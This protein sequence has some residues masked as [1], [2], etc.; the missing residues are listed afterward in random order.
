MQVHRVAVW[1]KDNKKHPLVRVQ[2]FAR[3]TWGGSIH[4]GWSAQEFNSDRTLQLK[5]DNRTGEVS[6]TGDDLTTFADTESLMLEYAARRGAGGLKSPA[7]KKYTLTCES[8]GATVSI[9][10]ENLDP[11]LDRCA[12]R[13]LDT[14]TT[15]KDIRE[16]MMGQK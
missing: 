2:T 6:L 14:N 1:C 16:V 9:R 8:C 15:L 4:P 11:I 10:Q 3:I 13:G 12:T 5:G 7:R